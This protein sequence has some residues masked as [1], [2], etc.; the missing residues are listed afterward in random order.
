LLPHLPSDRSHRAWRLR[1]RSKTTF[2]AVNPACT[3]MSGKAI[4][5]GIAPRAACHIVPTNSTVPAITIAQHT[6]FVI[7]V[8][9]SVVEW[10]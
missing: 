5:H 8:V 2:N 4:A 10:R 6:S 3:T 7:I 9:A 1:R